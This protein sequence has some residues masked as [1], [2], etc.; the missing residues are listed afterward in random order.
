MQTMRGGKVCVNING[1]RGAYFRTF[2]GLRQG[3]PLSPMLFNLVAD[4]LSA[5][6]DKAVQKKH[7]TDILDDLIPGGFPISNMLMTQL[8]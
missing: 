6:L 3:D 4:A 5:L 7:I 2:R 1:H 8:L